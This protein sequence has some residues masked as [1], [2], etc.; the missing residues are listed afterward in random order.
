MDHIS[1]ATT[2]ES[3]PSVAKRHA[4]KRFA[5]AATALQKSIPDEALKAATLNLATVLDS[6]DDGTSLGT[7]AATLEK[8]VENLLDQNQIS[9]DRR[10]TA[11]EII[12]SLFHA[13]YPF[14]RAFLTVS[15]VASAVPSLSCALNNERFRS[16]IL[17]G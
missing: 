5:S 12:R 1:S 10:G 17:M 11:K 14:A 3:L 2:K 8:A 16:S 9:S 6:F 4:E 7:A 15:K 13:S